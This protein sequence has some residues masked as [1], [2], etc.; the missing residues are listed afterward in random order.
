MNYRLNIKP[1]DGPWQGSPEY[2][3][4]DEASDKMISLW[5]FVERV[6]IVDI[7]TGRIIAE[8]TNLQ[9]RPE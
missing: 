9:E 1:F 8:L 4:L 2:K 5:L 3:Y 7:N 6:Q